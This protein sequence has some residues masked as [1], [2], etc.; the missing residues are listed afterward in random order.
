[1]TKFGIAKENMFEFWD[2]SFVC[3]SVNSSEWVAATPCVL[4]LVLFLS[5]CLLPLV[6]GSSLL[7]VF[8]YWFYFC[9]SVC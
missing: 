3:L 8:Y 7:P 4:L 2:V 1:M 9:L 6:G 5:V